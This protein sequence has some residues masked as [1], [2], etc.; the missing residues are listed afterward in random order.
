MIEQNTPQN[1]N[2]QNNVNDPS[3]PTN[4][5]DNAYYVKSLK[6][7]TYSQ[8]P[9]YRKLWF[10]IVLLLFFIPLLII[11]LLTGTIYRKSKE[12]NGVLEATNKQKRYMFA[13]CFSLLFLGIL[14]LL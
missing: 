8:V 5:E 9:F 4:S 11:L 10:A 7:D 14:R 1:T 3:Q 12:G 6:Y 2:Q 13:A